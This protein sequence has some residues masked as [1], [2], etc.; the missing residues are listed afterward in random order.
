VTWLDASL[1]YVQNA[2]ATIQDRTYLRG[3]GG[4]T[5]LE[6]YHAGATRT[7]LLQN[8]GMIVQPFGVSVASVCQVRSVPGLP[9][10]N[11]PADVG[12]GLWS[13]RPEL[14]MPRV[15]PGQR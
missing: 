6:A 8:A 5:A 12:L 1:R 11:E 10:H 4:I 3:G 15:M 13:K 14:C 2:V 7:L 9:L